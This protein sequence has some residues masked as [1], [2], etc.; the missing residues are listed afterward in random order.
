[1]KT[2]KIVIF[3]SA[4]ILLL[5]A[6]ACKSTENS[7]INTYNQISPIEINAFNQENIKS[8]LVIEDIAYS[9][10]VI[11][12]STV[13]KDVHFFTKMCIYFI[14]IMIYWLFGL[15]NKT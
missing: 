1:M 13:V 11:P 3:I 8:T 2:K 6:Y 10:K 12:S 7:E 5:N 4:L 14:I 15:K 9:Q